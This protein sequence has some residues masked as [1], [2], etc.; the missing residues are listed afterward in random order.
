MNL[1]GHVCQNISSPLLQAVLA[2]GALPRFFISPIFAKWRDGEILEG[3][4]R[5]V[6]SSSSEGLQ[7]KEEEPELEQI[8]ER[9]QIV[10]SQNK[11]LRSLLASL[12]NIPVCV[13][14]ASASRDIRGFPLIYVNKSFE[15]STGYLRDEI[16]GKN[17]RFL[18][19]GMDGA[20]SEEESISKLTKALS[21]GKPVKVSITNFR[22]D[23]TPFNNLLAVKPIFDD[24]GERV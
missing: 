3:N 7:K 20:H 22:K 10:L 1:M 2:L 21:M 19:A 14:L 13:S 24:R 23:G 11:W 16:I 5:L 17:C 8:L 6:R 9:L 18:Q 12:E 15:K 4:I